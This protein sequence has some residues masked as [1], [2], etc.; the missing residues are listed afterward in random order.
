[1]RVSMPGKADMFAQCR[2]PHDA[3]LACVFVF[4][5]AAGKH[6]SAS[7]IAAIRSQCLEESDP[8][9]L[10]GELRAMVRSDVGT[11]PALRAMAYWALGKKRDHSLMSFFR[12]RLIAEMARD[13]S[14]AYQLLIALEDLGENVIAKDR[15][16]RPMTE[17]ALNSRDALAYLA[18][19]V[20]DLPAGFRTDIGA[21]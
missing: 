17:T 19:N 2:D 15:S 20:Q 3:I 16:G 13:M 18:A 10:A 5:E 4:E 8:E 9:V 1:M 6:L 7:E 12:E 14:A 21:D 11:P